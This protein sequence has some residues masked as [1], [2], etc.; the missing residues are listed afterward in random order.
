[1]PGFTAEPS[2][3]VVNQR[4]R[5]DFAFDDVGYPVDVTVVDPAGKP[6][7]LGQ[8]NANTG[9][10]FVPKVAGAWT[11]DAIPAQGAPFQRTFQVVRSG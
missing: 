10:W 3:G 7:Y 1:M 2:P 8:L 4:L 6:Q 9:L 11:V 5:L